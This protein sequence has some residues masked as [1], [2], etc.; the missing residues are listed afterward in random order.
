MRCTYVYDYWPVHV[1]VSMCICCAYVAHLLAMTS[2]SFSMHIVSLFYMYN[3]LPIEK[4]SVA[5]LRYNSHMC[6]N[7]IKQMKQAEADNKV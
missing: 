6:T 1:N 5:G 7:S 3:D 2:E 4:E